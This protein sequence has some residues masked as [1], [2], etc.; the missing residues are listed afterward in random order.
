M[1]EG[2]AFQTPNGKIACDSSSRGITCRDLTGAAQFVIGDYQIVITHPSGRSRRVGTP[3]L[4]SGFFTSVDRL[5][6]CYANDSYALCTAGPSGK[7]VRIVAGGQATFEGVTGSTDKGGP[8]MPEG[9]SFA[10]PR[11][12][13]VC[14]SSSRGITCRDTSTGN[15]FTI[16]DYDVIVVNG[17]HESAH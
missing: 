11:G 8:S 15:S 6:R 13:F 12:S 9:T 16:G 5:E 14:L 7:G 1:P 4:Y 2:T 10:T 3:S 17:G